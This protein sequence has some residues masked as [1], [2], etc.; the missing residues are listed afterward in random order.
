MQEQVGVEEL[1]HRQATGAGQVGG[2]ELLHRQ[3]TGAGPAVSHACISIVTLHYNAFQ[4]TI[5]RRGTDGQTYWRCIDRSCQG[6]TTTDANEEAIALIMIT[7]QNLTAQ[8]TVAR[9]VVVKSK[10]RQIGS[11]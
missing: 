1:L 11:G 5:N 9:V 3:A 6:R 7:H 4:Y 10:S 8:A 2:E